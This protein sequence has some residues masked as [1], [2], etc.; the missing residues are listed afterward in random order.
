MTHTRGLRLTTLAAVT[1]AVAFA[2][3]IVATDADA[4]GNNRT[5]KRSCGRN[6][7]ASGHNGS[8]TQG[9]SW[10]QTTKQSGTCKGRLS[11]ALQRND[12]Y[13]SRRVY[14]SSK[15]AYATARFNSKAKYGLHWGCDNCNVTRS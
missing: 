6:Y 5:V 7:V 3:L 4:L 14:G 15:S 1:A 10:A 13:Q 11:A 9:H 12:G 8:A 2:P